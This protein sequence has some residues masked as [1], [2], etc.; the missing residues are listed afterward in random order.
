[1]GSLGVIKP[2]QAINKHTL[3]PVLFLFSFLTSSASFDLVHFLNYLMGT[4]DSFPGVGV[5]LGGSEV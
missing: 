2:E 5:N 3:N 1:M 4:P